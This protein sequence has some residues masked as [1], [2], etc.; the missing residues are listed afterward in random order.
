MIYFGPSID[1]KII[2]PLV[3]DRR[4]P[5]DDLDKNIFKRRPFPSANGKAITAALMQVTAQRTSTA[6]SI[7]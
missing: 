2:Y 3:S 1:S 5:N 7:A 6:Q 4:E